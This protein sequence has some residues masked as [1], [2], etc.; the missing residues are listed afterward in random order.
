[1]A[2][3]S[4][5]GLLDYYTKDGWRRV[6]V[7]LDEEALTLNAEDASKSSNSSSSSSKDGGDMAAGVPEEKVPPESILNQVRK[8][9]VIKQEVGGL[10]ISIKGGK[11]NKMPI[12]ISKIF[13]G[14][15]AD[16]TDAL[17]VGDAILAV[18]QEDLRNATHD[19]AVRALKQAGREVDLTVKYLKEVTPYFRGSKNSESSTG[20]PV[21]SP[22]QNWPEVKSI[23]LKL[24]YVS[25]YI[26]A[27]V[28]G[29]EGRSF[30]IFSS[31]GRSAC[32]LRC[33]DAASAQQWY[34]VIHT[35][36]SRLIEPGKSS[37]RLLGLEVHTHFAT[38]NVI[39]TV[40]LQ[41]THPML[42][43]SG[44]N[45]SLMFNLIP[46]YS[47]NPLHIVVLVLTVC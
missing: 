21:S 42:E 27:K 33:N 43:I 18:N 45:I 38:Q 11:E 26:P 22:P 16:Q 14:L 5:S 4:R 19:E 44:V 8:V 20:N 13:K 29:A 28:H 1:M 25:R 39:L 7:T 41:P 36:V 10:G 12:L 35:N 2:A 23:N 47:N 24:C 9:R 34:S 40:L 15:A 3:S 32:I 6:F 46:F 17:Y 31:D 37:C 30:E